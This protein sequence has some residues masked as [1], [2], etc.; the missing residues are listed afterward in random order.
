MCISNRICPL[1]PTLILPHKANFLFLL[2]RPGRLVF[3]WNFRDLVIIIMRA[4][5]ILL[6]SLWSRVR[7]YGRHPVFPW[8]I[9]Q[10]CWKSMWELPAGTVPLTGGL[11]GDCGLV[12]QL[13]ASP[14][15]LLPVPHVEEQMGCLYFGNVKFLLGVASPRFRSSF[16]GSAGFW[17]TG[18]RRISIVGKIDSR[19]VLF[20]HGPIGTDWRDSVW[21]AGRA[22]FLS[23]IL[24]AGGQ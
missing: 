15:F 14:C 5:V 22:C 4:L 9:R 16:D 7:G 21:K 13:D 11:V 23:D 2:R 6:G 3:I 10:C 19:Y 12:F 1:I 20:E 17:R 8:P 18:I 24:L